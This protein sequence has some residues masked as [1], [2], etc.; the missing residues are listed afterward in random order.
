[1]SAWGSGE[2]KGIDALWNEILDGE[3][4]IEDRPFLRVVEVV[5][6]VIRSGD[7]ILLEAEQQLKDGRIRTRFILPSEKKRKD[8]TY[9]QTA[10]RGLQEEMQKSHKEIEFQESSYR[11]AQELKD[12]V[13]YPGLATKFKYHIVEAKISG[14]PENDFWTNEVGE[15]HEQVTR[16]HWVWRANTQVQLPG[17]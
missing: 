13:S 10:A 8:E 11:Q 3:S 4:S 7:R 6:L 16:H 17:L 5:Q 9:I 15:R 2:A 12:S 14:L 1:M